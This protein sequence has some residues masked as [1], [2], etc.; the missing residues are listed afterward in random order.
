MREPVDSN[1]VVWEIGQAGS[2]RR[3]AIESC[4]MT[5]FFLVWLLSCPIKS[6]SCESRKASRTPASVVHGA[7]FPKDQ[8]LSQLQ[9]ILTGAGCQ[10]HHVDIRAGETSLALPHKRSK[11]PQ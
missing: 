2:F 7:E 5:D 9:V 10:G 4:F 11:A 1:W 6:K 8:G 3:K